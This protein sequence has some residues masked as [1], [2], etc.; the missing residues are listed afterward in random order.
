MTRLPH[1][2]SSIDLADAIRVERGAMLH[3]PTPNGELW[4]VQNPDG[5]DGVDWFPVGHPV[6]AG[7]YRITARHGKRLLDIPEDWREPASRRDVLP[8]GRPGRGGWHPGYQD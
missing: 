8:A 1:R 7:A 6:P 3:S 4:L 2:F 5:T